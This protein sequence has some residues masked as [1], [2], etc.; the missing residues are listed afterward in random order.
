[1][2]FIQY[3]RDK[4]LLPVKYQ[5]HNCEMYLYLCMYFYFHESCI[6]SLAYSIGINCELSLPC[7]IAM[8]MWVSVYIHVIFNIRTGP[9][10]CNLNVQGFG[11]HSLS[12][13][14]TQIVLPFTGFCY[15]SYLPIA[16]NESVSQKIAYFRLAK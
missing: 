3:W 10:I 7:R 13:I 4:Y 15:S 12:V 5:L 9:V 14:F 16:A 1:M 11:C 6:V 2:H 8:C